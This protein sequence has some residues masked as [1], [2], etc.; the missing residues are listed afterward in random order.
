MTLYRVLYGLN[1]GP[2]GLHFE[3]EE[4][5]SVADAVAHAIQNYGYTKWQ[6]VI[7]VEW[8]ARVKP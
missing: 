1:D 5:K 4:F 7:V 8:E 6:I 2:E 3:P